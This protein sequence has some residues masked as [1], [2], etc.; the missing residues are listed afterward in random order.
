[1]KKIARTK[2]IIVLS[3]MIFIV[4]FGIALIYFRINYNKA[5]PNNVS[6]NLRTYNTNHL[7]EFDGTDP[8]KP[9]YLGLNGYVYDVTPGKQFYEVGGSYHYLAGK[10]SSA[11]LN[12]IGGDII[13][14]KYQVIGK[15][16]Q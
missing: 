2:L 8:A 15:L 5:L 11:E 3:G 14:K 12:L 10:D 13:V 6:E 16:T 9:I 4:V 1:M 7:A